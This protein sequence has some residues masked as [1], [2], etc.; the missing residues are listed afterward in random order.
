[1]KVHVGIYGGVSLLTQFSS[2]SYARGSGSFSYQDP[3]TGIPLD[4]TTSYDATRLAIL[5]PIMRLGTG[6]E[7]ALP[8]EFPLIATLYVNYMNGFLSAEQIAVTNSVPE[9]PSVSGI[10]YNG[11]GW[12]VDIGV[13]VPFRFGEKVKCG[14]LPERQ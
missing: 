14:T 8:M 1:M 10:T 9:A 12:S 7:Y 3:A 2:G 4:A 13:K 5:T 6:V 11:S